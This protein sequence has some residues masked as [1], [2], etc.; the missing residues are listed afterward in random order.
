MRLGWPT[1][2][3]LSTRLAPLSSVG[4]LRPGTPG[5]W[6]PTWRQA[7]TS[8][9]GRVGSKLDPRF[10]LLCLRAMRPDLLG[11]LATGS[12]H[13]TIYMPD[14]Q[15]LSIP[16]PPMEE[17][18]EIVGAVW[19]VLSALGTAQDRLREQVDLLAEHRQALITEAV[20]GEFTVPGLAA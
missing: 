2:L 20:T 8:P 6:G 19:Q 13:K 9:L 17:Q 4:L 1:H 18:A 3:P 7:R 5:S 15:S 11:R 12:T 10:L 16:L 14:I